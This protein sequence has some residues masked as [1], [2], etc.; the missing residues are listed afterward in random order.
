MDFRHAVRPAVA[1]WL[2]LLVPA[3]R[4]WVRDRCQWMAA[5]LAFYALLGAAPLIAL[6]LLLADAVLGRGFS[7]TAILPAIEGW[8]GTE[9]MTAVQL[10]M[11]HTTGMNTQHIAAHSALEIISLVI[12]TGGYFENL[13]NAIETIWNM[14]REEAKFTV[15][16]RKK[17]RAAFA[18]TTVALF[19]ML[20]LSFGAGFGYLTNPHRWTGP[21]GHAAAIASELLFAWAITA[22]LIAA[23]LKLLAPVKLSW[24]HVRAG[25]MITAALHVGGREAVLFYLVREVRPGPE[26]V[27]Q[28]VLLVLL[29][30]YYA[31]LS[32]LYGAELTRLDVQRHGGPTGVMPT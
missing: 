12:G 20:T 6:V 19:L 7:S 11:L 30:M 18:A 15:Q 21:G 27:G 3:F 24:R 31:H 9:M 16:L 22:I 14:R 26:Y 1:G 10:L 8:L 25:A 4:E 5:G 29:W 32:F 28:T 17:L 23:A 13:E 2:R